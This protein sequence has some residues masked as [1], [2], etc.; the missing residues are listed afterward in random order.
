MSMKNRFIFISLAFVLAVLA[1]AP[2]LAELGP[3]PGEPRAAHLSAELLTR[4]H[5]RHIA[6]D[7]ALSRKIF[8]SYLK[9][10]DGEKMIFLQSDI[11]RFADA[12]TELDDAILTEDLN[13]PFAIFD[14]YQRRATERLNYARSLLKKGFDFSKKESYEISRKDAHWAKSV[15]EVDDLWR[16][17]V[18]NE[19][20]LLKLAGKDQKG[21]VTILDKRYALALRRVTQLKSDDVFQMFMDSYATSVDPHTNY[22]G[23]RAS[24]DFDISMRLSLVGIGALLY[25]KDDYTTIRELLPGGAAA[26]SGQLK[27]GDRIVGVGQGDAGPIEDIVG[28]RIDDAVV[29]I[30]GKEDT[31]VVLDILPAEA[32]ADAKHKLVRLVRKKI[33]LEQQS[34][35]KSIIEVKDGSVT[36]RIGV[37]TLP[38][39]YEDFAA[40]AR[41]DKNY[42]SASRDVAVL[43]DEL[44]KAH[45]DGVLV[46]L[47]NNGGGS[48]DEAVKLTGLFID[49]GPVVQE[50]DSR[51]KVDV[52]SDTDAGA[53]WTGPLGVLINHG[54]ASASEI[55]T[56]AIQDYGRGVVIGSPSFGK[57]T[58][59]TIVDL[60]ALAK[61]PKP[62]FGEIKMTIAQ[63]FR[64]DGGSTQLRGVTPDVGFPARPDAADFGESSYDNAL[65]WSHIDPADYTRVGDMARI[66]PALVAR[67][68]K[69][70]HQDREFRYLEEDIARFIK[71]RRENVISLNETVRRNM[72]REE[73]AREKARDA[74]RGRGAK[75]V[76]DRDSQDDGMLPSERKLS[77]ELAME[78][79]AEA[80]PDILLNE[81][82]HVVSD[83]AAVLAA[84]PALAVGAHPAVH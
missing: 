39:F 77:T 62:E 38:G 22:F 28:W 60:D 4:Y 52:K 81:A 46:D 41:G 31:V 61:N 21:I 68:D 66:V 35:K 10:L 43:L 13:T 79:A 72:R 37:I 74:A 5:Y 7:D 51:G 67:H 70:I 36:H 17:R 64:I 27:P 32:G 14:L 56:A 11:D 12:R 19:W 55:F 1:A 83:E 40:H 45:V 2:A 84:Q 33:T 20:L 73:E 16:K 25:Q 3:L 63:F 15:A 26:A 9:A 71:V 59:Q 42:K 78:K 53:A 8:D 29:I 65:P 69:R 50:R 82:A 30:R 75:H 34:A 58:V 54:S 6:L 48:L 44:K 57:G 80:A 47:R 24:Q 76:A 18:K 23:V 49:E